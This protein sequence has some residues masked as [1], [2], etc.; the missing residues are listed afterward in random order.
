VQGVTECRPLQEVSV[1]T[2][3]RVGNVSKAL[4][5][6]RTPHNRI[7]QTTSDGPD[8]WESP[9]PLYRLGAHEKTWESVGVPNC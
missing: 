7:R 9:K 2:A 3:A 4:A 1:R 6:M 5:R 8:G